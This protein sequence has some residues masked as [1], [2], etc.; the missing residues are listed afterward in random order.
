MFEN[1]NLLL[2]RRRVCL[3]LHHLDVFW[4]ELVWVTLSTEGVYETKQRRRTNVD[5]KNSEPFH[6]GRH[7]SSKLR[8]NGWD[9][10]CQHNFENQGRPGHKFHRGLRIFSIDVDG[11]VVDMGL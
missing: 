2:I 8:Y 9:C 4:S 3:G 7:G 10:G 6:H 5:G 1:L 11:F